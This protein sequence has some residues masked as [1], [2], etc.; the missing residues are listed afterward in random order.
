MAKNNL[1]SAVSFSVSNFDQYAIM[2]VFTWNSKVYRQSS[3]Y[4][5]KSGVGLDEAMDYKI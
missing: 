4:I 2:R 3:P 5:R 1:K